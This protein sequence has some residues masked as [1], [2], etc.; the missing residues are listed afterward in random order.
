MVAKNA[1][2]FFADWPLSPYLAIGTGEI[3]TKPRSNLVQ[4]GAQVR[5]ISHYELGIGAQYYVGSKVLVR[6]EYRSL[7]A[8]TQ[9]DEQERLDQWMLGVSIFF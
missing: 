3:R 2:N 1:P 8:L 4:S 5:T 7:L 6:A 9:R